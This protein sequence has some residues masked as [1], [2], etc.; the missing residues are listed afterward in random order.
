M[1][2]LF[3]GRKPPLTRWCERIS[4]R[5]IGGAAASDARALRGEW[6]R[7]SNRP[8]ATKA[9]L[10]LSA[11]MLKVEHPKRCTIILL[12]ISL[13]ATE[14]WKTTKKIAKEGW[15]WQKKI[16]SSTQILT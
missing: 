6:D 5:T 13:A 14:V 4:L 15:A 9:D 11:W 3:F 7:E 8:S 16:R 10:L 2:W 12:I 1:D